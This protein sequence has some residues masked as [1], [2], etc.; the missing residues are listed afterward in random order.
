M[1]HLRVCFDVFY[2][3][4]RWLLG[5]PV[6][7]VI[8]YLVFEHLGEGGSPPPSLP[9]RSHFLIMIVA[10]GVSVYYGVGGCRRKQT[11][12]SGHRGAEE[13]GITFQAAPF[14]ICAC[15]RPQGS[16][17]ASFSL[18]ATVRT[19]TNQASPGTG[20]GWGEGAMLC[21]DGISEWCCI[22]RMVKMEKKAKIIV[23]IYIWRATS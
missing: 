14:S 17:N 3:A 1:F 11:L 10:T 6:A 21:V 20:R 7:P 23:L 8:Y 4:Q 13:I 16:E 19:P 12:P 15:G 5:P 22:W 18:P 2:E 9:S